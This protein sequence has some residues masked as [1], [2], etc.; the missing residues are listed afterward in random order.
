MCSG[1]LSSNS[2]PAPFRDGFTEIQ[3]WSSI[4]DED[5]SLATETKATGPPQ[6]LGSYGLFLSANQ[7]FPHFLAWLVLICGFRGVI[8]WLGELELSRYGQYRPM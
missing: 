4:P 5:C 2:L 8:R 3:S 6:T 1:P 7:E